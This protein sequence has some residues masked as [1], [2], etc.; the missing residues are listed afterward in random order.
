MD[1]SQGRQMPQSLDAERFVLGGILI[2][3]ERLLDIAE[4]VAAEDFYRDAHGR[5]FAAML[6][7]REAGRP[8]ELH[9]VLDRI[10]T[11]PEQFGGVAY[12]L[13]LGD[14]VPTTENLDY[15]AKLVREKAIARQLIRS[16]REIAEKA[17]EGAD[18]AELVEFAE[19]AI[20]GVSKDTGGGEYRRL[21][22]VADGEVARLKALVA[23]GESVTGTPSGYPD[24][25]R[26][27]AGLQRSD[28]VVLA[29]RPSM[30]K[31]A[32][33][34]N[35]TE[36]AALSG[37]AVG[38]FSLEMSGEA[39]ASRFLCSTA[40]VSAGRARTGKLH[41][42]DIPKLERAAYDLHAMGILMDDT[43]A[44]SITQIRG[45]ARRMKA[46]HPELA[47]VV[48]D[49]IGLIHAD[50]KVPREQQ[51]AAS[52]R[53]LKQLAKELDVTVLVLSQLN[54]GVESRIDKRP[55]LSDLRESGAIEQDA[56]V[57]LFIY[58]DE[59]YNRDSPF[60]GQAEVI[61]AKQRNG[62]TGVVRLAFHAEHT[63]FESLATHAGPWVA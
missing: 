9:A 63:R 16:A 26:M 4:H 53:G 13:G 44:L 25:D 29:A 43:P 17:M 23:R 54:R 18:T 24:L 3:P 6:E 50:G 36:H 62:P 28:M 45:R 15:Y 39:L 59:Y 46:K 35:I 38:V 27:L 42:D 8:P 60:P 7:M 21:A 33:A 19:Q 31:T 12:V 40:R 48:V 20:L 56:D 10:S 49:Y 47:L 37:V 1:D 57:I 52:S 61:V 2:D 34:M 5:L 55:M 14:S 51:V 58:R 41:G 11:E 22:E 30:G 32:L